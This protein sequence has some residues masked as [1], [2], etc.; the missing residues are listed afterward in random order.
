MG[1]TQP[2]S[3]TASPWWESK[4]F[5]LAAGFVLTGLLGP[6]LQF[7]QKRLEWKNQ[8]TFDVYN[9]RLTAMRDGRTQLI[10]AYVG[11]SELL[12]KIDNSLAGPIKKDSL[13]SLSREIETNAT[14]RIKA[15]ANLSLHLEDFEDAETIRPPVERLMQA[16]AA[17][18]DAG[19]VVVGGKGLA[20]IKKTIDRAKEQF[21]A[22]YW[23]AKIEM[24][25]QIGQFEDANKKLFF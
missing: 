11:Y 23:Q 10:Q 21:R 2:V 3:G 14:E 16:W 12:D 25:R 18:I 5:L 1:E 24:E 8:V 15:N 17:T 9:K 19:R 20:E 6:W 7:V 22:E 4:I 13:S